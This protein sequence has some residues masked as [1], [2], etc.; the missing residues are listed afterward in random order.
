MQLLFE[1]DENK[2]LDNLRKHKVSFEEAKTVFNDPFL[3]TF[4]DLGHS[5]AEERCVSIG[6]S[7][8]RRTLVVIHTEREGRIRLISSRKATS[9]E[10]RA[11]ERGNN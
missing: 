1:W 7:S 8:K 2:A 10:R 6:R 9:H 3:W 5:D 11:Y 4:P